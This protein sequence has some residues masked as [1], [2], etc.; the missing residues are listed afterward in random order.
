[1]PQLAVEHVRD[2]ARR[3]AEDPESPPLGL[4]RRA[5]GV[6]RTGG[7]QSC[8]LGRRALAVLPPQA[9]EPPGVLEQAGI[10]L[11]VI[12]DAV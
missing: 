3:P 11:S 9:L 7:N 12:A 4:L 6:G 10:G 5:G 8:P 2:L 1:M